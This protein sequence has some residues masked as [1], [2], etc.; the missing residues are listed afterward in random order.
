MKKLAIALTVLMMFSAFPLMISTNS[1]GVSLEME[2]R[3]VPDIY[4]KEVPA[5]YS[6]WYASSDGNASSFSMQFTKGS[7]KHTNFVT[8]L[9]AGQDVSGFPQDSPDS[10]YGVQ[11]D[12]VYLFAHSS[13]AYIYVN[14]SDRTYA[15]DMTLLMESESKFQLYSGQTVHIELANDPPS[16][17]K[18]GKGTGYYDATVDKKQMSFTADEHAEYRFYTN[19]YGSDKL[20]YLE[21]SINYEDMPQDAAMIGYIGLGIGIVCIV[22]LFLLGKPEKL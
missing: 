3:L 19:S 15:S 17:L 20:M 14:Y 10:F 2:E 18:F 9:N 7:T 12:I 4:V 8:A 5:S 1:E 16:G 21:F 11:I 22:V 6:N 13:S